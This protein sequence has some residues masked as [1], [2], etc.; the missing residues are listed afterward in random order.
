MSIRISQR[1]MYSS[2]VTNMNKGLSDLMDSNL[3]GSTEKRINKP[4]D[5]PAG[6]ARVLQYRSSL[7]NIDRY[8]RNVNEALGWLELADSTLIGVGEV[9]SLMR[10]KVQQV[11][12]GTYS[13]ANRES[14]GDALRGHFMEL[15]NLANTEYNGQHIFAGH[16]TER[17]PYVAGLGVTCNDA[18][19][20]GA[21]YA[22]EG[23]SDSTVLIQFREDGTAG[24]AAF[25]YSVDGGKTWMAGTTDAGLSTPPYPVGSVRLMAG[26]VGV[27][28]DGAL[29]V[30][31]VDVTNVNET[32]NGT[33][34]YVRPTAIYQGDDHDTQVTALYG[35][36]GTTTG[37]TR[38]A[39]NGATVT[40]SYS[41]ALTVQVSGDDGATVTYRYS[42]DG[43][44][45]WQNTTAPSGGPLNI[46]G[47]T[48]TPGASP[49]PAGTSFNVTASPAAA[50]G[51][52][53]PQ[54][55]GYFTRD[56]AVRVDNVDGGLITYSYSL[57]DGK[58]WTQATAPDTLLG[59]PPLYRLPVP[60]GFLNMDQQPAIDGQFVVRPRRADINLEIS[61][62]HT[63]T[64]NWVGKD[65]FGG[66]YRE[67]FTDSAQPV[68]GLANVF[69]AVG[70]AIAYAETNSQAGMQRA[71]DEL[72]E[73]LKLVETRA[74]EAGG[75][76]NRL[77]VA[78][79]TLS[80][81]ELSETDGM[82][83]IEDI[84]VTVLMTKL[85][86]QQLAYNTVLKS[87]S[88]I[89]QMNLSNFI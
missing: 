1:Q 39:D 74:T 8:K 86:Q 12:S 13:A 53:N 30:S 46:P 43:G 50:F 59:T 65:I 73:C 58:N 17:A 44:T 68:T 79:N 60:G 72:T 15:L 57:D 84:D 5:D 78:F 69:E 29:P 88:M 31:T 9:L 51:T 70:R 40:G 76:E 34:I 2:F 35:A 55:D 81:R 20:A 36:T 25:D 61:P 80:M 38:T 7:N 4:S 37:N 41:K 66:L 67:P 89:M 47:G 42:S 22:A 28:L 75:R 14:I 23:S 83:K 49:I 77:D 82:S 48:L 85:A 27:V 32:D 63:I 10:E 11:S 3:Q 64:V 71:I 87:S 21:R 6:M 16:K 56:V 33:W 52:G 62:N 26:G 19:F 45:T 54:A 24:T 18:N